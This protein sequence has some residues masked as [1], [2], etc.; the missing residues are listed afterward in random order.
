MPP[1]TRL[2]FAVS[3]LPLLVA[4]IVV[5]IVAAAAL[6]SESPELAAAVGLALFLIA[7]LGGRLAVEIV[8]GLTR[9]FVAVYEIQQNAVENTV[10][11]TEKKVDDILRLSETDPRFA[12]SDMQ[13]FPRFVP[14]NHLV[15]SARR[16]AWRACWFAYPIGLVF[17]LITG[18]TALVFEF[19]G[20][21][22]PMIVLAAGAGFTIAT[23]LVAFG[24]PLLGN[25][26][27]MRKCR[28]MLR[29]AD[30][31]EKRLHNGESGN[32]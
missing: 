13:A 22:Y 19:V 11:L 3:T 21:G 1:N 29:A 10:S 26:Q 20:I 24:E 27:I 4:G 6:W 14:R 28:R 32:F 16:S 5:A 9:F 15:Q 31:V 2:S 23:L 18:C 17:T 7:A 30:F 8:L 25:W 12:Y